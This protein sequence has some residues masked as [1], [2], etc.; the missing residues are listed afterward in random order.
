L[1]ALECAAVICAWNL[2]YIPFMEIVRS[3]EGLPPQLR[4]GAVTI[5]N[6]DGVHVGHARLIA[7][8][9]AQGR[10]IDGPAVVFTFDPH[11]LALLKP[12][13][14][15][16]PMTRIDRKAEL[17]AELGVDALVAYPTDRA[18]LALT[19]Q[20]FF[21]CMLRDRLD[22]RAVVEGPNFH[23][24]K[25]RAGTVDVLRELCDRAAIS[26][27]VVEPVVA[28][29]SG[30]ASEAE[31]IVSSSRV[32]K[33]IQAGEITA[34]NALLTR[35]YRISGIVAH[36]AAR[37]AALGFPTANLEQVRTVLPAL[38][39]YAGRAVVGGRS[40]AAAINVGSNPTFGE[41]AVKIEAHLIDFTGN[42]YDQALSLDLLARLRDVQPFASVEVLIAQL[43][44]DVATAKGLV[45]LRSNSDL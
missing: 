12:E 18:L 34:A 40:Y 43:R 26:L 37:G 29:P 25:D 33:L 36:G 31:T 19:P 41:Q 5:G 32:R 39:V 16:T 27:E 23:F 20:T 7:R 22:A 1:L 45:D 35:P 21:D 4:G 10:R 14:L 17:L 30:N 2:R 28:E 3:L 8:L 13:W 42:L 15:P 44:Q 24:G 6:F 38:G 9:V 11:P